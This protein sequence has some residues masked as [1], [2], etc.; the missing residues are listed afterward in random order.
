MADPTVSI[1][2]TVLDKNF[3]IRCP[4]T[5]VEIL[6]KAAAYFE[7]HLHLAEKQTGSKQFDRLA[8]MAAL[9]IIYPLLMSEEQ[10]QHW[11][12]VKIEKLQAKIDAKLE[13]T[14]H[15]LEP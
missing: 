5:E 2:L 7:E 3:T 6:K 10:Q 9:N 4:A 8:V 12:K 11:L 15:R 14:E 1:T 13:S